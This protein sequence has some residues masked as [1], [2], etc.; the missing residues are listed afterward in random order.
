MG[1]FT[2]ETSKQTFAQLIEEVIEHRIGKVLFDGR[3]VTRELTTMDRYEYGE[4]CAE[5]ILKLASYHS[6]SPMFAYVLMEPVLDPGHF[7]ETVAVNRG[8]RVKA[9]NN[10]SDARS[11]LE[12]DNIQR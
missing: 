12:K 8:M 4:F 10:L 5:Q 3:S 7:G 6:L 11:W 9:F 1:P 2:L